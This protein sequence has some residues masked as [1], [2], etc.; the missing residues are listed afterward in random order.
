MT[1]TPDKADKHVGQVDKHAGQGRSA[2]V[3]R[4]QPIIDVLRRGP[5]FF[6]DRTS[7][8]GQR[9]AMKIVNPDKR[10]ALQT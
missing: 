4:R 6:H 3:G 2:P 5:V 8:A 9:A 7:K 10:G 1:S